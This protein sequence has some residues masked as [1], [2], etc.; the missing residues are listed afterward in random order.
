M[1]RNDNWPGV[2]TQRCAH[3]SRKKLVSQFCR[4]LSVGQ[5]LARWDGARDL[6]NARV[7]F[8]HAFDVDRHVE[9]ID[10]F[11]PQKLGD[12]IDGVE[13]VAWRRGLDRVRKAPQEASLGAF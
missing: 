3:I 1:A 12:A 5:S 13:H 10:G 8:R 7:E 2:L 9:E 6:V 11:A 4:D